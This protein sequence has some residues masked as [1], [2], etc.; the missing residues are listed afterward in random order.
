M[1]GGWCSTLN[2]IHWRESRSQNVSQ[3][4]EGG[5]E[6]A[7]DEGWGLKRGDAVT[8]WGRGENFK[9]PISSLHT[10]QRSVVIAT[11]ENIFCALASECTDS[12]LAKSI[13]NPFFQLVCYADACLCFPIV[14]SV[15]SLM[16]KR[17]GARWFHLT[18]FFPI[19][20][21]G[22]IF[23]AAQIIGPLCCL[24]RIE[25]NEN[26]PSNVGE[27][28]R[29]VNYESVKHKA[30][31]CEENPHKVL[32]INVNFSSSFSNSLFAPTHHHRHAWGVFQFSLPHHHHPEFNNNRVKAPWNEKIN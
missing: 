16:E 20:K 8:N 26:S 17:D 11:L 30:S 6:S 12:R 7:W 29:R 15:F 4:L 2:W 27:A 9:S 19:S 18:F 21:P 3:T 13:F 5:E 10:H 25:N 28:T 32:L 23:V 22:E 24:W 14:T 1:L 31:Q